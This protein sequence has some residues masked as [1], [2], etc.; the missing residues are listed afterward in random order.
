MEDLKQHEF[1]TGLPEKKW[2]PVYTEAI[3]AAKPSADVARALTRV[4]QSALFAGRACLG[5]IAAYP[6]SM[7]DNPHIFV[8][9]GPR[10][11]APESEAI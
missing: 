11:T 6:S 3:D 8:T 1:G 7:T 5:Q 4:H 9:F 2:G 10:G